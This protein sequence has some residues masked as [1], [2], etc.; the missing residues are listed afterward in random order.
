MKRLDKKAFLPLEREFEAWVVHEIDA[1]FARYFARSFI[2][3]VS[4]RIEKLWPADELST[5]ELVPGIYKVF[6]LQFKRPYPVGQR[7]KWNLSDK[8][9]FDYIKGNN[10]VVYALPTFINR[11]YRHNAL[12]HCIFWRPST[13]MTHG[14]YYDRKLEE[15]GA[16]DK[17]VENEFRWGSFIEQ[18]EGCK[19]GFR[20]SSPKDG[21]IGFP[22]FERLRLY[23]P[24]GSDGLYLAFVEIS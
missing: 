7:L 8:K 22:I 12:H 24:E 13:S 19:L 9:Q 17:V 2:L 6:G 5:I 11:D 3:A 18:V 14:E 20:F 1:Y 15:G 10:D 16:S 21:S 4:P 23:N